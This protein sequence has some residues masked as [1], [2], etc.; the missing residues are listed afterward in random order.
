VEL[1]QSH[2]VEQLTVNGKVY[3]SKQVRKLFG[4]EPPGAYSP[5][6]HVKFD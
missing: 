4:A 2:V 5:Y 3:A 1:D 6:V